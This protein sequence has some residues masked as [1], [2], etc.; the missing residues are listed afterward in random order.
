MNKRR[1]SKKVQAALFCAPAVVLLIVVIGIPSA[2]SLAMSVFDWDGLSKPTFVGL[3]NFWEIIAE[4]KVFKIGLVNNIK[5]T[6]IFMVI[7][8][9]LGLG[10][11][12]AL[13]SVRRLRLLYMTILFIP[14]VLSRVVVARLWGWIFNPFFGINLLFERLGWASLSQSWLGNPKIALYSLAFVDNWT[15]WGFVMVI[16]LAAIQQIDPAYYEAAV[17]DGASPFQKFKFITIPLVRSTLNF[18]LLLT[19]VWSLSAFDF[20]YIM[21]QGGPGHATEMMSTWIY[22]QG[23]LNF[24]AGYASAMS[25]LLL[26]FSVIVIVV[27]SAVR[28][29]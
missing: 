19:A 1:L 29:D 25:V 7:P 26:A 4:D 23:I 3:H 20:S 27:F 15:W 28:R 16:F 6:M 5:W 22:K 21:T 12:F 11:A 13:A 9:L 24:R 18:I 2:A 8:I 14:V 17:I 10:I